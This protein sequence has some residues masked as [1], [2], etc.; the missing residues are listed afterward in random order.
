LVPNNDNEPLDSVW[1]LG[2]SKKNKKTK[3][4]KKKKEKTTRESS[5][6]ARNFTFATTY[7]GCHKARFD[8]ND[9]TFPVEFP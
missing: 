1:K 9:R 7:V 6:I 5:R 2:E 4:K 3:K 8:K